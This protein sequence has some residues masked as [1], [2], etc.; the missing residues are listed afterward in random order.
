MAND[1]SVQAALSFDSEHKRRAENLAFD[2]DV[3][4]P[5]LK[6]FTFPTVFLPF[7]PAEAQAVVQCYRERC[8]SR[9]GALSPENVHCL[10]AFER[11]VDAALA[12][13]ELSGG[14]FPR[15]CGRSLKDA[16]PLY[17][18]SARAEY[19]G[20]LSRLSSLHEDNAVAG[21]CL[22]I[23][24]LLKVEWMKVQSGAELMSLLLSSERAF[25][26]LKDWLQ[27]G[28]L[29]Q[30]VLR[31]WQP[32]MTQ[33]LEFRL[34]VSAGQL[35]GI[36]Q[37]EHYCHY[38][39]L[40]PLAA[41]LE[42]MIVDY[43]RKFHPHVGVD[44]YVADVGYLPSQDTIILVELGPFLPC[45]G[46][47]CFRWAVDEQMLRNGPREFRLKSPEQALPVETARELVDLVVDRWRTQDP[48]YCEAFERVLS[49][50]GRG[51]WPLAR[52]SRDMVQAGLK[53]LLWPGSALVA[54]ISASLVAS[55]Q[56]WPSHRA[57]ALG[58]AVAL[59]AAMYRAKAS[60]RPR[61]L[62][63]LYG[64]LKRGFHWNQKFL[65]LCG[66]FA[67]EAETVNPLPLVLGRCGVPYLL[68]DQGADPS[69]R[70]VR[71][72][73]WWVDE[74]AMAG[75]DDY[76]G[77]TKAYYGRQEVQCRRLDKP[78]KVVAAQVYGVV[79]TDRLWSQEELSNLER[80]SEYTQSTHDQLY[81]PIEHILVKQQLYLADA[82]RYNSTD[83]HVLPP[84]IS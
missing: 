48:P 16:D 79:Q 38:P 15:L 6:E 21:G 5:R 67:G 39:Y 51:F 43:W 47:S 62:L 35:T 13:P 60:G 24:A 59:S 44:S 72:E 69:A 27:F 7:T 28:E 3:W 65:S 18:D 83:G 77:L 57:L 46:A 37:Y 73:L 76:E 56:Q 34:F 26:D 32:E 58:S 19:S 52:P 29:E 20:H 23:Q 8:Q 74:E 25:V 11:R 64:T 22:E 40:K 36:S 80:M 12:Q 55:S 49:E 61:R 14:A 33:D 84:S 30:L 2:I 42:Q 75:L 9:R 63:F 68:L 41:K 31:Q 81:R 45:T 10:K 66:S 17:P 4:Y 71:G 50:R 82:R 78:S 70:K 1:H 53:A 54:L